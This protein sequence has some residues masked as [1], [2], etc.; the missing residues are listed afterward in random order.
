MVC[1]GCVL[2]IDFSY[3]EV[4][5]YFGSIIVR[6]S[7]KEADR[8]MLSKKYYKQIAKILKETRAEITNIPGCSPELALKILE[9]KLSDFFADDNYLFDREKFYRAAR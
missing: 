8:K 9:G 2:N 4:F 5:K 6:S 3:F 1:S 7:K